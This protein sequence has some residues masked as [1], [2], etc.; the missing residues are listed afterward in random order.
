M[1]EVEFLQSVPPYRVGEI[2]CFDDEH[3]AKLVKVGA[4]KYYK[5]K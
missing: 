4:A 5:R 2:A 1:R 3:A